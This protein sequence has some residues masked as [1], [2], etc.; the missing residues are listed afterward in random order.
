MIKVRF[1]GMS[2]EFNN[3]KIQMFLRYEN[4]LRGF[5]FYCEDCKKYL[6]LDRKKIIN[7]IKSDEHKENIFLDKL[8]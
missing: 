6:K 8:K 3:D 7:H 5:T 4:D 2:S 1:K